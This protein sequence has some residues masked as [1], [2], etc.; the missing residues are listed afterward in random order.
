MRKTLKTGVW[1][2]L[3]LGLVVV[4]LGSS[5]QTLDS[6]IYPYQSSYM[7]QDDFTTGTTAS[8]SIGALGW[9]GTG[10]ITYQASETN[11]P[12]IVRFDT[13]T[14]SGTLG[15]ISY[16]QSGA[17]DPAL[18]HS[19]V[20]RFRLNNN[21]A[22]TTLRIGAANSVAG[23]PPTHGIYLEKLDADTNWFCVTRA[24][25]TQTRTDTTVPVTTNMAKVAYTR[26]SAGVM[27]AFNG[28]PVC[29]TMTTNIPSTFISPFGYV[30]NSAAAL[31]SMDIEYSQFVQTGL[32]R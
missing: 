6:P 30:V 16:N 21:D 8:G 13:T 27:F 25:G 10:N 5:L 3:S 32:V 24:S 26:N 12:G 28:T 9:L 4:A 14:T 2:V 22:N 31:K 7:V 20:W 19:V 23:T 11:A 1:A 17:I 18:P 29:G 15:R